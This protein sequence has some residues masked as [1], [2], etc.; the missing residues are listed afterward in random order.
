MLPPIEAVTVCINYGDFLAAVAPFNR[1]HFRQWTVVTTPADEETREVCRQH[2][3]HCLL[4][5]DDKRDG[6]F[7]KGRLVERGLQ[8]L[9][10]DTWVL[11]LDG[12]ICLPQSF[13]FELDRA[14]LEDRKVYGVD[15]FMVRGYKQWQK[16]LATGYPG[17]VQRD[18]PHQPL[19]PKG[20]PLGSR[21]A[22]SDGYVPI[23]FFQLWHRK[24]GAEEWRGGR[25]KPY[26]R[27]HGTAV[28]TDV[29]HALQWDRRDR[30]LIPE[31]YVAHL[32]SDGAYT[33]RGKNWNGRKS[34]RF[35]PPFGL[36]GRGGD[37]S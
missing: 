21:W 13:R 6:V 5:N 10:A 29:Q 24:G 2:D 1:H 22:G 4:S 18:H 20:Y 8:H 27:A 12:D 33:E 3:I 37:E 30:A 17:Q 35:G 16:L 32:E 31:L 7:S 23:G 28:R 11:H 34:P 19:L 36:S 15:R 26:P 25:T 14:H 9:S